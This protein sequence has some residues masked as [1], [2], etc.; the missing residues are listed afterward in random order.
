[1]KVYH[2]KEWVLMRFRLIKIFSYKFDTRSIVEYRGQI[3]AY[4]DRQNTENTL[5][6]EFGRNWIA[7]TSKGVGARHITL[8]V[9]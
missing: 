2:K 5:R 3:K 6:S 4:K 7:S 8:V 9:S 1:M